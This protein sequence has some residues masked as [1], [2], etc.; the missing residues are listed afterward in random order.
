[1]PKYTPSDPQVAQISRSF[2]YH[3][4]HG[5]QQERYVLLRAKGR[6]LAEILV[7]NCPPS[8]ELSL[9]LT[10]LEES[11]MW[12]NAAIARNEPPPQTNPDAA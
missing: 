2:V 7:E 6:S 8:R 1:M 4:P 12:A 11:I 9:A 10:Q 3:P 5:D